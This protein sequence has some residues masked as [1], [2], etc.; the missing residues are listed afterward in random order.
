[1]KKFTFLITLFI[2]LFSL[3]QGFAQKVV[4]IGINHLTPDGF[5]FVATED[6]NF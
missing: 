4:V 2:T 3:P 1:M 6:I 5:S